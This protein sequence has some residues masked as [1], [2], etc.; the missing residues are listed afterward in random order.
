MN[1]HGVPTHPDVGAVAA[2]YGDALGDEA[3]DLARKLVVLWQ[4]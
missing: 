2:V 4:L 1:D 3:P